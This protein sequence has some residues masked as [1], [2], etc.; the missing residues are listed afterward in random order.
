[1]HEA[2]PEPLEVPPEQLVHD[3]EPGPLKVPAEQLLHV[4]LP[5]LLLNWPLGHE[6]QKERPCKGFEV[7][8]AQGIAGSV[9]PVQ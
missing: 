1:M 7:P 4:R 8:A 6:G 9:P 5:V 3:E 2:E